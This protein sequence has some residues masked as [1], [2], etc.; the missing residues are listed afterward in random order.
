M[1]VTLHE[2][3]LRAIA[4][5]AAAWIVKG[6][7]DNQHLLPKYGIDTEER[8]EH[9]LAQCALETQG[10]T[11]LE[12][13][14]F[15]TT[16]G[17]L[18]RVWPSRFKTA[19]SA[20]PYLRNPKK[21]ALKVYSNRMGNRPGTEDGWR[22]RGSGCKMTTGRYNYGVV[23]RDTGLP[24]T[25]K[26]EMLRR[27]PEALESACIY[28]KTNRLNRFADAGNVR[29]LTKAIQGGYG[30][31]ADRRIYTERAS[32]VNW[33]TGA[34]D[35]AAHEPV[36]VVVLRQ[37]AHGELVKTAQRRLLEHGYQIRV[38]GDFGGGTDNIVREFQE[39][40][41]LMADGVIGSATWRALNAEPT[42]RESAALRNQEPAADVGLASLLLN[43]IKAIFNAKA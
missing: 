11:R 3:G 5:G 32:R 31:L 41:G 9:F 10:F 30:G 6:I 19:A 16:A 36:G 17:R 23:E 29:G 1:S 38:D 33:R 2:A 24:V 14:L 39:D 26:P 40:H 34:P 27:F 12:E 22:F 20:T 25:K 28:W 18:M 15:Y 8:V 7:L 37:G 4:P 13:N 42:P 43:L 21:L 35:G